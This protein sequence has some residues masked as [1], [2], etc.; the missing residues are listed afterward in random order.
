MGSEVPRYCACFPVYLIEK[1]I[2]GVVFFF[3]FQFMCI[4]VTKLL[5]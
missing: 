1:E 5:G 4:Q 2:K 3:S